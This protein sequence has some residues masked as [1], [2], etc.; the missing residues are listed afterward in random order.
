FPR[1]RPAACVSLADDCIQLRAP[2]DRGPSGVGCV[3]HPIAAV[4]SV[5]VAF[6]AVDPSSPPIS[7]SL[8]MYNRSS[9][10]NLVSDFCRVQ[11]EDALCSDERLPTRGHTAR[12]SQPSPSLSFP[13]SVTG[14]AVAEDLPSGGG[15]LGLLVRAEAHLIRPRAPRPA[16]RTPRYLTQSVPRPRM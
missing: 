6:H 15:S 8:L 7:T 5:S 2:H 11:A 10:L 12:A 9:K 14:C 4:I 13:S 3:S 1:S 16:G